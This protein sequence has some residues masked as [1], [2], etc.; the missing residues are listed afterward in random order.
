LDTRL[1]YPAR[2]G[3]SAWAFGLAWVWLGWVG[4]LS[5]AHGP[6]WAPGILGYSPWILGYSPWILGLANQLGY[7]VG[8]IG[9]DDRLWDSA[10][11]PGSVGI[12][13]ATQLIEWP[14]LN[15]SEHE[16]AL[17]T[18]HLFEGAN[19]FILELHGRTQPFM[20]FTML[21]WAL[22]GDSESSFFL[23]YLRLHFKIPVL[24]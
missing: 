16:D 12:L 4:P 7:S 19:S 10:L 11:I 1:W 14:W 22:L 17:L 6:A 9:L 8:L 15:G 21:E 20:A 13:A 18:I 3:C 5:W 2:L 24:Q 23:P